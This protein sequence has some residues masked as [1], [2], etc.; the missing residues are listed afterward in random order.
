MRTFFLTASAA[1]AVLVAP[2]LASACSIAGPGP[3]PDERVAHANLAVWGE[4]VR[5]AP[6]GDPPPSGEARPPGGEYRYRFRIIETYKGRVRERIRL[7]GGT[8][9]SLCEAGE[10]QVGQRFGLILH[11][12]ARPWRISL[13][14]FISR[15]ELRQARRP[16][17][18]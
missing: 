15:R 3:T 17:R 10:L 7:I 4:V 16:R 13:T 12:R 9:E 2:E 6:V 11:G 14:S 18:G 8:E 1:A 5:K